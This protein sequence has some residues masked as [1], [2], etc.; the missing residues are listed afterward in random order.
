MMDTDVLMN[1]G[2]IIMTVGIF[3]CGLGLLIILCASI[4][5]DI[6]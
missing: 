5:G 4:L 6:I 2:A 1:V 3:I